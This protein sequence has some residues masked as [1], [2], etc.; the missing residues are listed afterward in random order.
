MTADPR[1]R[2]FSIAAFC[3]A[4]GVG[5]SKTFE[6]IRSGALQAVKRG[7]ATLIPAE[8][9]EAWLASLPKVNAKTTQSNHTDL[10]SG[11]GSRNN[12]L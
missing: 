2:A 9:A 1:R 11:R 12:A 6:L 3:E 7:H 8:A 10:S 4:H 5:R